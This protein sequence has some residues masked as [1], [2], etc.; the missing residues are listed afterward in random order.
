MNVGSFFGVPLAEKFG[1]KAI[2]AS[3][4]CIISLCVFLT[5]FAKSFF[6]LASLYGFAFGFFNGVLYMIP[7][8]CGWKFYP[9]NKGKLLRSIKMPTNLKIKVW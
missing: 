3:G 4:I 9:N 7:V 5:S 8:V 6:M 1:P 2:I